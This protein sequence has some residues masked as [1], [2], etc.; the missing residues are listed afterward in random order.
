M[1]ERAPSRW[2]PFAAALALLAAFADAKEPAKDPRIKFERRADRVVVRA[3][4]APFTEYAFEGHAKP[5][6][7][8]IIGPGGVPMTRSWPILKDVPDEPHDHPHHESL[9]F[10]HGEVNGVDFWLHKPDKAGRR[11]E[12]R[13]TSLEVSESDG[14]IES[15][16]EWRRPDGTVVMTDVR[17][18]RFWA[19]GGRQE[20]EPAT[21]GIDYD[22]RLRAD[23]GP[24]VLGDT[25]E[26]AMAIRVHHA[27]Q[28][29]DLEGSKGAAG[30]I[31]NSEGEEAAKVWGRPARW[32]DYS[33]VIE[34]RPV[35]IAVFDHPG[36]LRH[37]TRWHARG[38]GLFAA[39]PF[40][41]F[42]GGPHRSGG[43]TIPAGEELRLRY[44]F[45][46]HEGD[47]ESANIER[48]WRQWAEGDAP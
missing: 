20:S 22:I 14:T 32:V 42:G 10:M 11:P 48:R 27:L 24:V 23:H 12:V 25:K 1:N 45:V 21:R 36:N 3:D 35:G 40:H 13:Q 39:N 34:G 19:D 5:I 16:N 47:A 29:E 44:R 26:G 31:V 33:G 38:Y 7:F 8:P 28:L 17:R 46:F 41:G 9:W 30:R 6:L 18:L 43:H 4:E 2:M 37:P 15:H